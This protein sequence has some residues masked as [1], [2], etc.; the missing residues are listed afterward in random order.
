MRFNF[1]TTLVLQFVIVGLAPVCTNNE[2]ACHATM[3]NQI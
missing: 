1:F 3:H 2:N